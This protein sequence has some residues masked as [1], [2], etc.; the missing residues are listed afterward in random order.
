MALQARVPLYENGTVA[1]TTTP[2]EARS[3]AKSPFAAAAAASSQQVHLTRGCVQGLPCMP[4]QLTNHN[5]ADGTAATVVLHEHPSLWWT[6]A[7]T[8]ACLGLG[9]MVGHCAHG[10][11]SCFGCCRRRRQSRPR[12]YDEMN[13]SESLEQPLLSAND[14]DERPEGAANDD[15]DDL[16]ASALDMPSATTLQNRSAADE[17]APTINDEANES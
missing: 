12:D 16:D 4:P 5:A 8:V 3:F 1:T 17:E 6:I 11:G 7:W 15:D 10:G 9:A 13:P 2:A 14:M